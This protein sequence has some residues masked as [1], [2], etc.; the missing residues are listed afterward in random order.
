MPHKMALGWFYDFSQNI[1][2]TFTLKDSLADI[3]AY[4][5]LNP[6]YNTAVVNDENDKTVGIISKNDLLEYLFSLA[7]PTASVQDLLDP[8]FPH[9]VQEQVDLEYISNYI[10]NNYEDLIVLD[11][12]GH[13][14][15]LL[16]CFNL[17]KILLDQ[18]HDQATTYEAVLNSTPTA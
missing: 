14:Q 18:K 7:K 12:D 10:I 15:S 13:Y 6:D 16:T 5:L 3:L 1:P 8:S 4:F 2:R 11:R 9:I 17:G